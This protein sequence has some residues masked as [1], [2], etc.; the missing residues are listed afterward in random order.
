MEYAPTIEE[1]QHAIDGSWKAAG[2]HGAAPPQVLQTLVFFNTDEERE[3]FAIVDA[4]GGNRFQIGV[5]QVMTVNH[6]ARHAGP[7]MRCRL[8]EMARIERGEPLLL[9]ARNGG[10]APSIEGCRAAAACQDRV[11][12]HSRSLAAETA[13]LLHLLARQRDRLNL[14]KMQFDR[15]AETTRAVEIAE[16][17]IVALSEFEI[18]VAELATAPDRRDVSRLAEEIGKEAEMLNALREDIQQHLAQQAELLHEHRSLFEELERARLRD[19]SLLQSERAR[20]EQLYHEALRR[21]SI[22]TLTEARAELDTISML[23][24]H[25]DGDPFILRRRLYI[26]RQRCRH[27]VASGCDAIDTEIIGHASTGATTL[28]S[29]LTG[30]EEEIHRLKR[31]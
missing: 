2:V 19:E 10:P 1:V 11:Q 14:D 4:H 5:W 3:P 26:L 17:E 12:E 25:L 7:L 15:F 18:D 20:V 8:G 13:E 28:R 27:S 21:P 22:V 24:D 23:A 30:I 29:V 16:A 9:I 6:Q 31:Q